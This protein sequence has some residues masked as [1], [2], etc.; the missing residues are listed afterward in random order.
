MR[1]KERILC[2]DQ[3]GDNDVVIV[4]IGGTIGDIECQP[5]LEAIRQLKNDVRVLP[6]RPCDIGAK[7]SRRLG[8]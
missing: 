8:S 6:L 2:L 4:E 7:P 3:D 1:I 5:F